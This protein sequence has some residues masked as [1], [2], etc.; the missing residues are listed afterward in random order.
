MAKT[1]LRNASISVNGVDLSNHCSKVTISTEYDDVDLTSF[2]AVLKEHSKGLG[3]GMIE[4]DVFQDFAAGSVDATLWPISQ[5]TTTVPVVVKPDA[6]AV[7]ATNPSYTMQGYLMNYSPLDGSVG[8]ASTTSVSFQNGA[9][10]GI[11]RATV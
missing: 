1:V 5:A 7:S 10:T 2:G 9:T 8:D 3:D 6:G 11:V 4:M